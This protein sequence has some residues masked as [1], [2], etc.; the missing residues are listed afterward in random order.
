[1]A[2]PVPA[3]ERAADVLR[4]LA[5]NPSQ[6]Q[7]GAHIASA[8]RLSRATCF[9]T[10]MCLTELGWLTRDAV[11]KTY[12]LGPELVHL[13]WASLSQIPGLD[14]ARREMFYLARDLDVG[15]FACALVDD[16]MVILDRAGTENSD[17]DLPGLGALRVQ[18]RPPLGSVYFA[19]SDEVEVDA[20]LQRIGASVEPGQLE[21]HRRALAAI[22]LRGYSIGGGIE[23]QLQLD[24]LLD[25]LATSTGDDRLALALSVA[26]LVRGRPDA[27]APRQPITHLIGPA[28]DQLGRVV[29]T[30]TITGRVGQ[31]HDANVESYAAALLSAVSRVTESIGGRRPVTP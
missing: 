31:V 1:M 22:R 12:R 21:A 27:T 9:A 23:V 24:H 11:R 16:D 13:G 17:F 18:A 30:L 8:L 28:F 19:W 15:C 4:L 6:A 25:Q 14:V 5:E 10:L 26:D 20:W 3:V 2:T 29:L 7:S